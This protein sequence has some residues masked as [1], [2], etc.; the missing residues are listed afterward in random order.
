MKKILLVGLLLI[1][2]LGFSSVMDSAGTF[3]PVESI[4]LNELD[5]SINA[6]S[7]FYENEFHEIFIQPRNLIVS[8]V[9][10]ATPINFGNSMKRFE[11]E[12]MTLSY[13]NI[14]KEKLFNKTFEYFKSM[15]SKAR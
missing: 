9:D 6:D 4:E 12:R 1:S 2:T 10:N 3:D 14:N 5:F 11:P 13:S 8:N 7:V 15:L